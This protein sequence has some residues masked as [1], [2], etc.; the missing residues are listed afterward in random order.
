MKANT[1]KN[2]I[3]FLLSA[4]CL[5]MAVLLLRANPVGTVP[6]GL[7]EFL[8]EAKKKGS[9][10]DWN[11]TKTQTKRQEL[12]ALINALDGRQREAIREEIARTNWVL[13]VLEMRAHEAPFKKEELVSRLVAFKTLNQS[14][15][16]DVCV[17]LAASV[18]QGLKETVIDLKKILDDTVQKLQR[19]ETVSEV[20]LHFALMTTEL[21]EGTDVSGISGQA[22]AI[23]A[24]LNISE[25]EKSADECVGTDLVLDSPNGLPARRIANL[26]REGESIREKIDGLR[27]S[28]PQRMNERLD[29][30]NSLLTKNAIDF[31]RR[32]SAHYQKWALMNIREVMELAGAKAATFIGEGLYYC[33]NDPGKAAKEPRFSKLIN[34]YPK[35]RKTLA[36]ETG[37][38]AYKGTELVIVTW[39]LLKSTAENLNIKTG[40]KGQDAL[41]KALVRDLLVVQMLVINESLL[42]RPVAN[43][44]NETFETCWKYLEG[45]DYRVEVAQKSATIQ[46]RQLGDMTKP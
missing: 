42:E 36:D 7:R 14:S 35:F 18:T 34:D 25:W 4:I 31:Q 40:W 9:F 41:A 22:N 11:E 30:M 32:Q 3:I 39:E 2:V 26:I 17:D 16:V 37:I 24:F 5:V 44:Y 33:K 12:V 27:Y 19:G 6:N 43:L 21:L 15:Q 29:K 23:T 45:T 20:E 13:E 46:T 1:A 8:A 38:G 10:N 28:V